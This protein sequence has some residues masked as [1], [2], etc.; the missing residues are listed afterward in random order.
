MDIEIMKA[1]QRI[2]AGQ[3]VR[4]T[5]SGTV[6]PAIKTDELHTSPFFGVALE[7]VD[8]PHNVKVRVQISGVFTL[9]SLGPD[10]PGA[11]GAVGI[12]SSGQLVRAASKKCVSAPNWIGDCDASGTVT[13]RPRRDTRLSVLDFGA[14]GNGKTDEGADD[15]DA[16]QS[17]L[18]CAMRFDTTDGSVVYLPPGDYRIKK[19]LRISNGC[20]LEGAGLAYHDETSRILADVK[21][22]NFNLSVSTKIGEVGG[23]TARETVYCA[24]ALVGYETGLA[25]TPPRGRADYAVLRQLALHSIPAQGTPAASFQAPQMDGIRVMATGACIERMSVVS[26][27]RN[28]IE[29]S[30]SEVAP[31]V[32]ASGVQIRDCRLTSNGQNGLD[33]GS[34]GNDNASTILVMNVDAT[35]NGR[36]GIC[37]NSR[38]GSTFV[39][40]HTAANRRRNYSCDGKSRPS[41][42]VGC[43]AEADAPSVFKS[44]NTA[45]IG[46]DIDTTSDSVFWG[47]NS[48]GKGPSALRVVN[49]YSKVHKYWI[50][51]AGV[52]IEEGEE[53]TPQKGPGNGY[54][55]RAIHAG[56][57]YGVN[58]LP[59]E[60]KGMPDFKP[61]TD[62]VE[63]DGLV[64]K[65]EGKNEPQV[66]TSNTLGSYGEDPTIIHDFQIVTV[67]GKLQPA[68][69]SLFRTQVQTG[70]PGTKGRVEVS[71]LSHGLPFHTYYQTAYENGPLPGKL[72]LPE[73]WIGKP[74]DERR[75]GV[76]YSGTP[77]DTSVGS[78]YF[79]SPGDLILNAL[80]DSTRRG[81][82]GW[83]V[84]A[85][86]GRWKLALPWT[87]GTHY[88]IGQTVRPTHANHFLYRLTAYI[89]DGPLDPG[90]NVSGEED[91]WPHDQDQRVGSLTND[92]HLVWQTIYDLDD[93]ANQW[94]IE[95]LPQRAEKQTKSNATSIDQLKNDFNALLDKMRKANLL[96]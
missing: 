55:Y 87:R 59:R 20:I 28:G 13:I 94:C 95:P 54:K 6:T 71:L 52:D 96:E 11:V 16:I 49:D 79:Y 33:I 15:A 23:G 41:V 32:N 69:D 36:D 72:M 66:T 10:K 42:Y 2:T 78:C 77:F 1:A 80:D 70:P 19:P 86:C 73:A 37:D 82:I 27:R 31:V 24:I 92:K 91:P 17:A 12:D 7:T 76:V 25:M 61:D 35:S 26:F 85:A 83:A 5:G 43:Y 57:T 4:T 90:L 81:P 68:G 60:K 44:R 62:L 38:F 29:I 56:H 3:A 18:D 22:G 89:T 34:L 58:G 63:L 84:Q 14:V 39:S 65:C 45:V 21:S 47:F 40:C 50:A 8:P 46:G 9:R 75:I 64:W 53:Q 74:D 51:D 88:H 93:P 67:D 48:L 30:S